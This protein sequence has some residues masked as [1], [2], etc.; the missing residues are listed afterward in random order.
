[1]LLHQM[2]AEYLDGKYDKYESADRYDEVINHYSGDNEGSLG[3]FFHIVN[4]AKNNQL[5]S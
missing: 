4:N 2:L 3:T 1:M 5:T